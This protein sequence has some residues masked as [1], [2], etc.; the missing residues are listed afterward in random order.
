MDDIAN[1]LAQQV[2]E[3]TDQE[4]VSISSSELEDFWFSLVGESSFSRQ[5]LQA[6]LEAV[7]TNIGFPELVDG[8]NFTPRGW[9]I[10][11]SC[12]AAH[13]ILSSAL[14]AGLLFVL[15]A[16]NFLPPWSSR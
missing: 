2:G 3:G 13:A 12:A 16:I 7:R 10:Q 4:L 9:E 11:L 5:G 15:G 8:F 14:M 1:L 6:F